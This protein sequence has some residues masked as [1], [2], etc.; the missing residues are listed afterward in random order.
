MIHSVMSIN[1]LA[2]NEFVRMIQWFAHKDT[3]LLSSTD[4]IMQPK[5]RFTKKIP[6]ALF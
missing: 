2:K 5:E 6:I 4:I 3:Y 1:E